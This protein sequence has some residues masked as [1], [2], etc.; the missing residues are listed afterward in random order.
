LWWLDTN[1]PQGFCR[2]T[3]KTEAIKKRKKIK[4]PHLHPFNETP[5]EAASRKLKS[6]AT[7]PGIA[8]KKSNPINEINSIKEE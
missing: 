2:H 3:G 4:T 6:H 8:V 1:P 7:L 5:E